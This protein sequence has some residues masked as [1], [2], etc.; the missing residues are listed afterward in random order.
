[1]KILLLGLLGIVT[2]LVV[3]QRTSRGQTPK[4]P[5]AWTKP[6]NNLQAKLALIEEGKENGTRW[7]VPYL[8]LQYTGDTARALK[9]RCAAAHVKFALVDAEGKPVREG[10]TLPRSGPHPDPGTVAIPYRS[11]MRIWM[12][13]SNWGIPKDAAAMI[14]ADSGA[15]IL[16]A[17]EK[18]KVFLRVT[19]QADKLDSDP[20]YTWHGKLETTLKVTWS[21][22]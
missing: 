14:S 22:Q 13:C 21:A 1:M 3:P 18:D 20:D 16:K 6:V 5:D 7:L 12:G 10:Y 8:E 19:I 2:T 15:W 17:E 11:S 4:L 9:V